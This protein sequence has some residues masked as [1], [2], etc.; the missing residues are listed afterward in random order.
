MSLSGREDGRSIE[1]IVI[2]NSVV[3]PIEAYPPQHEEQPVTG[4]ELWVRKKKRRS[5]KR[6]WCEGK[7][8][9][10]A[11]QK[12]PG[13]TNHHRREQVSRWLGRLHLLTRRA[14]I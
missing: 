10:G 1:I 5:R 12:E 3:D 11:E 2:V 13:D 6:S 4:Q 14:S 9:T 7:A 8:Q